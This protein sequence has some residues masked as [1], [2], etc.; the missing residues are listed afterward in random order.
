MAAGSYRSAGRAARYEFFRNASFG[1]A[2][3]TPNGFLIQ[4]YLLHMDM[5]LGSHIRVFVQLQ[6]G[7]ENGR[8]G[9]PRATEKDNLEIHQGFVDFSTSADPKAPTLR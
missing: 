6:S 1:S 9:G 5:H 3:A 7:L 2:P 8:V 4:R